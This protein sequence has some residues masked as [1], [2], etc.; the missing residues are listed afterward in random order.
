MYRTI[1][2]RKLAAAF[3][4]LNEGRVSAITNVLSAT[5]EHY[6]IGTHALAGTRRTTETIKRWY[7]R[8][9]RLLPDIHFH[10][11]HIH[12]EGPP[13]RTLATVEW[14]ESNSGTDGVRTSAE[15][16]NVIRL[17]WG[18]VVSVRIYTDTKMLQATLDRLAAKGTA[19]A[20]ADP[21]TS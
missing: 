11:H 4:G 10:L 8:L 3:A 13:W 18:R 5:A 12:V 17:R 14:T 2:R 16:T 9:L 20:R 21:I 7:E 19:E 6:F 15:G 1:V